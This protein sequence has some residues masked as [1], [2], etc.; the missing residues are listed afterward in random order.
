MN[1]SIVLRTLSMRCDIVI[2]KFKRATFSYIAKFT[3]F[4]EL[5]NIISNIFPKARNMTDNNLVQLLLY[6]SNN[7]DRNV[8]KRVLEARITYLNET[9]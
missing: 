7:G 5:P 4:P 9:K 8:N 3:V 1:F 6:G 2:L